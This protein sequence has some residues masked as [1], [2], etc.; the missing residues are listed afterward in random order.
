MAS[1]MLE[2]I[3]NTLNGTKEPVSFFIKFIEKNLLIEYALTADVGSFLQ[4]KYSRNILL[5]ELKVNEDMVFSRAETLEFGTFSHIQEYMLNG[6]EKNMESVMDLAKNNLQPEELFLMNGFKSMFSGNFIKLVMEWFEKNFLIIYSANDLQ[7]T[8]VL[9]N[10]K[11]GIVE[12]DDLLT[13]ATE[14]FGTPN[15]LGYIDT[16]ETGTELY[17]LIERG[18][19]S[20]VAVRSRFFESY[21]TIRFANI[22][23][24]I[25][26][27]L[28]TG[29]TL[30][31]DEFDA[32]I[33]PMALMNIVNIFHNDT[34]NIN[35]A[36]LIFN[37]HNPIFLNGNLYRQDEIKFVERDEDTQ[38]SE[39]YAL[40]DFEAEE[41]N[42]DRDYMRNYFI[43][44]YGA[45]RD[46]D[47]SPI[48]EELLCEEEGE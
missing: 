12:V 11:K 30:V 15:K 17:S 31:V 36:Q 18:D 29:G 7:T 28:A 41:T 26:V 33:H 40:S 5:E 34:I 16:E 37:T 3:P 42:E 9:D 27:A 39:L 13:V 20:G 6:F 4:E 38:Y 14:C 46:I 22:F 10:A 47:F 19:G 44:R 24:L 35:H 21:G 45:V 23:P 1:S 32:S 25:I 2:L 43:S 8:K 48:F